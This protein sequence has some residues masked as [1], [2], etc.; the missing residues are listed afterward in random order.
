MKKLSIALIAILVLAGCAT[1]P[2]DNQASAGVNIHVTLGDNAKVNDIV[3]TIASDAATDNKSSAKQD[4]TNTPTVDA[5][6]TP[7]P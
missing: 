1:T 2:Y 4:A 6:L 5:K 3:V 7:I